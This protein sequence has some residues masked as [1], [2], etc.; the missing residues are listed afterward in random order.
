MP[1]VQQTRMSFF[2]TSHMLISSFLFVLCLIQARMFSLTSLSGVPGQKK[3]PCNLRKSLRCFYLHITSLVLALMCY[4]CK[5]QNLFCYKDNYKFIVIFLTVPVLFWNGGVF[6]LTHTHTHTSTAK[7]NVCVRLY[8]L[9]V[10][11]LPWLRFFRAFFSVVRQM[12]GYN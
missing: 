11:M 5:L 10:Y 2:I 8:I 7:N 1:D 6:T 12:P 4:L 9:Y 3:F